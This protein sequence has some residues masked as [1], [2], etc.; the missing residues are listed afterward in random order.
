MLAVGPNQSMNR[1]LRDQAASYGKGQTADSLFGRLHQQGQSA[2]GVDRRAS[3][4]VVGGELLKPKFA[5]LVDFFDDSLEGAR[6]PHLA[7]TA[8]EV[9][10]MDQ[11]AFFM[12]CYN[13][14]FDFFRSVPSSTILY[15][16]S[17]ACATVSCV[18]C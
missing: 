2:C 12:L 14:R 4:L 8:G 1:E 3:E 6:L 9:L 7:D 5:E 13:H 17:P 16:V 10:C 18:A 15:R 11:R